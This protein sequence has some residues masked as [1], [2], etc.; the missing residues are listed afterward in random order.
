MSNSLS[1]PRRAPRWLRHT[2]AFVAIV[3]AVAGSFALFELVALKGMDLALGMPILDRFLLPSA[4]RDS[5]SCQPGPV[6]PAT[7]RPVLSA[8]DVRAAVWMLGW[9]AG[10]H[11]VARNAMNSDPRTV[12]QLE[13]SGRQ[14]AEMLDVPPPDPFVPARTGNAFREFGSFIESADRSTARA[15]ASRHTAAAC[16]LYKLAAF[17]GYHSVVRTVLAGDRGPFA[18]EIRHHARALSLPEPL[19][20]PM[21]QPI[22]AGR[23]PEQV[24]DENLALTRAVM[25][26]LQR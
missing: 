17:W 11:A 19:W 4:T 16:E 23:A 2:A 5:T 22:P 14:L 8:T 26:H 21:T 12:A 24:A 20:L 25:A 15:L 13:D 7:G 18:A 6:G 10:R 3:W 9:S 1:D